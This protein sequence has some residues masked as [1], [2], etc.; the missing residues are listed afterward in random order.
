MT[1]VQ[2][3]RP[4]LIQKFAKEVEEALHGDMT[5]QDLL[6]LVRTNA[7]RGVTVLDDCEPVGFALYNI[8]EYPRKKR[9]RILCLVGK[10]FDKWADAMFEYFKNESLSLGLDGFEACGR[11]GFARKLAGRVKEFSYI[12]AEVPWDLEQAKL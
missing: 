4:Y 6:Y 10:E 1:I 3:F 12:V 9:I 7:V 2:W 8:V 5:P 11:K